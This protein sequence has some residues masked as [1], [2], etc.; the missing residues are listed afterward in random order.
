MQNGFPWNVLNSPIIKVLLAAAIILV[1]LWRLERRNKRAIREFATSKGYSFEPRLEGNGLPLEETSFFQKGDVIKNVVRGV[2]PDTTYM[3]VKLRGAPFVL[4]EHETTRREDGD[5][6]QTIV[7]FE[8]KPESSFRQRV[9]GAHGQQMERAGNHVFIWQ[10]QG[11]VPVR[12]L[13]Q[14]LISAHQ[15]FVFGSMYYPVTRK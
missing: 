1:L 8:V 6:T 7:A 10:K 15:T 12:Q 11:L 5:S 3:L 14:F 13:E 2:L 4:F 9:G